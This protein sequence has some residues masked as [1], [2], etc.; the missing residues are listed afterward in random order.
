M[1]LK[2]YCLHIVINFLVI[3]IIIQLHISSINKLDILSDYSSLPLFIL[4]YLFYLILIESKNK[5]TIRNLD[6]K[7][8]YV[9]MVFIYSFISILLLSELFYKNLEY[10]IDFIILYLNLYFILSVI[11]TVILN[12]SIEPLDVHIIGQKYKFTQNDFAILGDLKLN[13]H[14]HESFEVYFKK[15]SHQNNENNFI[16]VNN[17]QSEKSS[18]LSQT[19]SHNNKALYYNVNNFLESIIRK[20][21]YSEDSYEPYNKISYILKRLI[22]FLV[23]IFFIPILIITI[24]I[25]YVLVKL[26]SKGSFI[27]TQNRVGKN[28]KL[29]KIYKIRTMHDKGGQ[30]DIPPYKDDLRIY[31]YG[32]FLR[33]SRLDE[34]PQFL[35]VIKGDMHISGPRA[36]WDQYHDLYLNKIEHYELRNIVSPGITGFAQVMFRYA[37]NEEDSRE[38]LMF[39]L[40]YIKTWSIWLEMEIGIR[41]LQ[42]MVNKKGI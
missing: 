3:L 41:T 35:N 34:L 20:S 27:Y 23:I 4:L 25:S 36:E 14:I 29:F 37:H 17:C 2:R 10:D 6:Q 32:Q 38:K 21:Y 11:N 5:I 30:S 31:K 15:V 24:P 22:D 8:R 28:S 19:K 18:F 33:K 40:Y 26:Q 9:S 7:I 16:L 42:V 13:Y 12:T 39:D 1:T